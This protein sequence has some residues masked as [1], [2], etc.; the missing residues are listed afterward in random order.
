[1]KINVLLV[2]VLI[3]NCH[4]TGDPGQF[5]VMIF[6]FF[7]FFAFGSASTTLLLSELTGIVKN[8]EISPN[9]VSTHLLDFYTEYESCSNLSLLKSFKLV[10]AKHIKESGKCPR[11]LLFESLSEVI[12]ELCVDALNSPTSDTKKL[13]KKI[14]VIARETTFIKSNEFN[15]QLTSETVALMLKCLKA[16]EP[17]S[18]NTR[19]IL[20]QFAKF[21]IDDESQELVYDLLLDNLGD[22]TSLFP[23]IKFDVFM[24]N[25]KLY[26]EFMETIYNLWIS[27]K[28]VQIPTQ[29]LIW[30]LL[31]GPDSS[32]STGLLIKISS[33]DKIFGSFIE[34]KPAEIGSFFRKLIK[35]DKFEDFIISYKENEQVLTDMK[36]LKEQFETLQY[37]FDTNILIANRIEAEEFLYELET[38][39]KALEIFYSI[40]L[41]FVEKIVKELNNKIFGIIS[42]FELVQLSYRK[43]LFMKIILNILNFIPLKPFAIDVDYE[44]VL[45]FFIQQGKD[46]NVNEIHYWYLKN[47]IKFPFIKLN[48]TVLNKIW[49]FSTAE[50]QQN[51]WL[52]CNT[53]ILVKTKEPSVVLEYFK[54]F[55]ELYEENQQEFTHFINILI[56]SAIVELDPKTVRLLVDFFTKQKLFNKS[57]SMLLENLLTISE[58]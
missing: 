33:S 27:E 20:Q 47:I 56:H 49:N 14:F 1:M 36:K 2:W 25:T 44:P 16:F 30:T 21:C 53:A 55:H 52:V 6:F 9:K 40:D 35:F 8:F 41:E 10:A 24:K 17:I 38:N 42:K 22:S 48:K 3:A 31:N 39:S 45:D 23:L 18:K 12:T 34:S 57:V 5:S 58:I 19:I 51:F 46:E 13:L 26:D 11:T 54:L 50:E 15:Y 7:L 37:I 43:T 4:T 32:V 29:F 28:R